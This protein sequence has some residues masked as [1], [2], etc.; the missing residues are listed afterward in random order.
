VSLALHRGRIHGIVGPNGS[1]KSTFLRLLLGLEPPD[2][3]EIVV[4]EPAG[5]V[6]M[7]YQPQVP[8]LYDYLKVGEFLELSA[9]L[10]D[11]FTPERCARIIDWFDLDDSRGVLIKALSVGTQMKV[12]I[13]AAFVQNALLLVLDEP[14][15]SVDAVG[16]ARLKDAIRDARRDGRTIVVATHML[17]FAE[18]LCDDVTVLRTGRVAYSGAIAEFGDPRLPLETRVLAVVDVER[19]PGPA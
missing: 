3:G 18:G 1:G 11:A 4:H 12:A 5:Q 10:A 15:N 14:T 9:R 16:I 8:A 17:D 7:A 2:T 6:R 19:P 13:A